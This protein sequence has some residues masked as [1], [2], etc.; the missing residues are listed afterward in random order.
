MI[1]SPT[2]NLVA[3]DILWVEASGN[4]RN[5]CSR[6]NNRI[7]ICLHKW[8]DDWGST[9]VAKETTGVSNGCEHTHARPRTLQSIR[10]VSL[11]NT[12]TCSEARLI[13]DAKGEI[14]NIPVW[15]Q[16]TSLERCPLQPKHSRNQSSRV[17]TTDKACEGLSEEG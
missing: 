10:I 2:S 15:L 17:L 9:S 7:L 12:Q 3:H 4:T 1:K 8:T 16:R 5:F 13:Y 14:S 6:H 11:Q